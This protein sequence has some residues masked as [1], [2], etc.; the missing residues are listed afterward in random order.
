MLTSSALT[1]VRTRAEN[2][3][4]YISLPSHT[5]LLCAKS[6]KENRW[7]WRNSSTRPRLRYNCRLLTNRQGAAMLDRRAFLAVCSG[8]GL[9]ST[10]MP[11]VL[12]AMAAEKTRVTREMIDNAA[13]IADV[14]IPDEYKD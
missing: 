12:W 7:N 3:R 1:T 8:L 9:T 4:V 14:P 10:L 6:W 11:G 2:L 13:A 5:R